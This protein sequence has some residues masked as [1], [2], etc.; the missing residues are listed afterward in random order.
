MHTKRILT[1]ILL[2][3]LMAGTMLTPPRALAATIEVTTTSDN[4]DAGACGAIMIA[5]LPGPDG[6]VSLREAICAANNEPG[7]D[8]IEFDIPLT[9]FG[10]NGI[11]KT[12]TISPSGALPFLTGGGTTIDGY[13][14]TGAEPTDDWGPAEI[15]VVLNGIGLE[16]A[17]GL[18][19]ASSGNTIRGLIINNCP[20]NGIMIVGPGLPGVTAAENNVIA[21][22]HIGTN[23]TA[24]TEQGNGLDG[25][26]IGWGA[27]NNLVGGVALASRNVISGNGWSGVELHGVNTQGNFVSGNY[28]G[29]T[30][31][32]LSALQNDLDGVRIYGGA[33]HNVV[34][35]HNLLSG[36]GNYGLRLSGALTANN[37]VTGNYIGVNHWGLGGIPNAAGVV[38]T[39]GASDNT[40]GG[41]VAGE[42][43]V[44]SSNDTDG[45]LLNGA[46]V[47]GNVISGNFIG[48]NGTGTLALANG[49]SG[50]AL[51]DGPQ[52]NQIGGDEDGQGNLIS[53]NRLDGVTLMGVDTS[54]NTI[55]GNTIGLIVDGRGALGNQFEG[56]MVTGGSHTNTIGPD[57]LVS[58]NGDSGIVIN[59][60]TTF[61]NT[62]SGNLIGTDVDGLTAIGNVQEGV[63]LINHAHDNTIGPYNLISGNETIG[64]NISAADGNL[65]VANTIGADADGILPL[66]NVYGVVLGEGAQDNTIA[67]NVISGNQLYGIGLRSE[68]TSGNEMSNNFIGVDETGLAALPNGEDGIH[69]AVAASDNLILGNLI[70]GNGGYGIVVSSNDNQVQGNSIGLDVP[71][72]AALGNASGGVRITLGGSFNLVGGDQAAE[73]NLISGNDGPGV[74]I[75][76]GSGNVVSGNTIGALADGATPLGNHGDGVLIKGGSLNN[77]IGGSSPGERN[78]ISGNQMVGVQIEGADTHDN[79]VSG[80]YVGTD[81]TGTSPLGNGYAGIEL[82][83]GTYANLIGGASDNE[84]NLIADNHSSGI[85]VHHGSNNNTIQNNRLGTDASGNLD[86]GN[87][88]HGIYVLAG[89]HDNTFGP[90]NVVAYSGSAGIYIDGVDTYG[91]IITQNSLYANTGP[92]I[93]LNDGGNHGISA[94]TITA[95]EKGSVVI[96]GEACAGCL[97]ELFENQ[98]DDWA[99]GEV[100]VGAATADGSGNFSLILEHLNR[101]Y[102]TATATRPADGTSMFSDA[103]EA[104]YM[105]EWNIYLPLTER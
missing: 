86:L 36:N 4:R 98:D 77:L 76:V 5:D 47:T 55:S 99:V 90:D 73:R 34:G 44:I 72:S 49:S 41:S 103:F 1:P 8:T 70:S 43:N 14:Q 83:E 28:I 20:G 58:G 91:N 9:D 7:P 25:V 79:V 48:T 29:A 11:N 51:M 66:D 104:T 84:S 100:Y 19:L 24:S 16:T 60:S 92:G 54:G 81:A 97:V 39:E 78:I 17:S 105:G 38:V 37:Q 65:V 59:G 75:N 45:V 101:P 85:K 46:G 50:I 26:F 96:S 63:R 23:K 89:G 80:N 18:V 40:I 13:T 21:G 33:H 82:D 53:G 15:R 93:W 94:P 12:W 87:T 56:V 88:G 2:L 42:R 102:L 22:N 68:G 3:A 57:N 95:T 10:Y 32:G 62:V 6:K 30:G 27:R 74:E 71:G 64:V 67:V 31:S 61:S 69:L 35:S 52:D